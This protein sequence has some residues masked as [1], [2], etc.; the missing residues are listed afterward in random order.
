M[1]FGILMGL[2]ASASWAFANVFI[3]RASRA[4]GPFRALIWALSTGGLALLPVALVL[5]RRTVSLGSGLPT[6]WLIVS[7]FAAV[8]AY[9]SMFFAVE[10]GRLSVVVPMMSSW[11]V[12]AAAISLTGRAGFTSTFTFAGSAGST[13]MSRRNRS[14]HFSSSGSR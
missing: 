10:R 3:Q 9:T 6:G 1:G 4:L 14:R 13:S 2:L 12:I 5:D 7:A 8:L 11:S